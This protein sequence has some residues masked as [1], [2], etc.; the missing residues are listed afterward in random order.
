MIWCSEACL[1]PCKISMM[2]LSAKIVH[3]K[4][5][6]ILQRTAV[7]KYF[8]N[9]GVFSWIFLNLLSLISYAEV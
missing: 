6:K 3:S 1:G 7:K 8:L 5:R 9:K 4:F 2:E